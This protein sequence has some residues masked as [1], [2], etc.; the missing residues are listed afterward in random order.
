MDEPA[1]QPLPKK[2]IAMWAAGQLSMLNGYG[3]E[4]PLNKP[5]EK[6]KSF[7]CPKCGAESAPSEGMI[8]VR[9]QV[10]KKSIAIS[11]QL[12]PPEIF[13]A[14]WFSGEISASDFPVWES[15][16]FNFKNGH[17]FLSLKNDA[18]DPLKHYDM[19]NRKIND[20]LS[21]PIWELILKYKPVYRELNRQFVKALK[22]P[23]PFQ[24]KMEA[25]EQ[26]AL[27]TRFQR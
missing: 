27:M 21:D 15:V 9:F 24:G 4:L 5:I 2:T 10:R 12:E 20:P 23:L 14:P 3:T 22:R 17:T 26:Y 18:G 7:A 6:P 16:T 25:P 13:R 11:R 1:F 8:T 19:T